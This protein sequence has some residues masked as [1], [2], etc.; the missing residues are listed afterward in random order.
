MS[1]APTHRQSKEELSSL[2]W[3]GQ[4][5][6]ALLEEGCPLRLVLLRRNLIKDDVVPI[7][8]DALA[9]RNNPLQVCR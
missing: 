6:R 3:L 9:Q 7:F 1:K 4:V 2:V 5:G 8:V